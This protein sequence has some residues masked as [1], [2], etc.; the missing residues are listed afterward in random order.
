MRSVL[1]KFALLFLLLAAF[2][3]R[4]YGLHAQSLWF[5]EGWSWHLARMPLAEMAAATAGDRSPTLYYA[6]LHLWIGVSGQ[7]EFAMR[8]LSAAADVA[9]LACVALLA[10]RMRGSSLA[11]AALYAICPAAIWYAQETRMYAL[12]AALTIGSTAALWIWLRTGRTRALVASAA[13]LALAAHSHYYAIF[14]LPGH[15]AAVALT[16][17]RPQTAVRSPQSDHGRRQSVVSGRFLPWLL[18][19]L[20][21]VA[22]VAPWLLAARGG[23]AYDDG[24]AFPLNTIDGR[25]FEWL[26]WFIDA[27]LPT[28]ATTEALAV[29]GV[30]AGLSIGAAVAQRRG[31]RA[32]FLLCVT[33]IPLLAAAV[34][35]RIFYPYRSV[36]HPR[37]LIALAPA[38]CALLALAPR[39]LVFAPVLAMAGIWT[40][41]LHGYFTEP[42]HQRD[43]VRA[44]VRHV[45]EAWEPGDVIVLS[46][47]NFA[48]DYYFAGAARDHVIALP[49]GL[50]GVL[51]NDAVVLDAFNARQPKR[52]RL[53]LWQDD[54][55]D[56]QRFVETTLRTNGYQIGEYNFGQ[57]RLPLYAITRT[58]MADIPLRPNGAQF[59]D[60]DADIELRRTWHSPQARR[61]D[62]FY[63]VL[64]WMPRTRP[65]R[66][67]KVF[68]HVLR[69]DGSIAFQQDKL[70]LSA[71]VPTSHWPPGVPQRDAY[72][73]VAPADLP[74]GEYRIRI[75]MYDPTSGARLRISDG[76]AV[77]VGVV[78]VESDS[79]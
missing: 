73:I 29:L 67:Y 56:P 66:D 79:R 19:A 13:L 43:D 63:A 74:P 25:M 50:H 5:D 30:C 49:S 78:E 44:A 38:V 15:A 69:P 40:P 16:W 70:T 64:E 54:V 2:A 28:P 20:G 57:I 68:V 65:T 27:G 39:R 34:A 46:R 12:V 6:L 3:L 51:A 32:A 76:D 60:G 17:F 61:G 53:F 21:V 77:V 71:L 35:V 1:R 14:L 58:P 4:V 55:V 75:G 42:T 24:F 45:S 72:A 18:A 9:A 52:V 22:V 11:A 41:V 26:R 48:A 36:F 7:S 33:V 62:W 37:Y 47:D 8:M 31:Q 10:Q 59:R 23:F